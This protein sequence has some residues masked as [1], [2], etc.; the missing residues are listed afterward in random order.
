MKEITY[1]VNCPRDTGNVYKFKIRLYPLEDG[2]YLPSPCAGCDFANGFDICTLCMKKLSQMS[3]KDPTM[4]SYTQ[5]I[6]LS[7]SQ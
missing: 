5:P 3:R 7:L 4:Q 6:T 1:E 2:S